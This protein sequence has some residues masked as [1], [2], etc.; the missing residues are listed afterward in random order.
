M[1]FRYLPHARKRMR[2]RLISDAEVESCL[3]NYDISYT[4]KKGNPI[5]IA[6]FITRR[7]NDEIRV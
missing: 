6:A 4:D 3:E 1:S 7:G 2:E 5:Y